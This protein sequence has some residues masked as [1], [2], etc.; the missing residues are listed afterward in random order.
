MTPSTLILKIHSKINIKTDEV[1][2]NIMMDFMPEDLYRLLKFYRKQKQQFPN[3]LVKL[4][5]Y[6]MLRSIAYIHALGICHRD[7]KPQNMLV[8]PS[9][10]NLKLCDFGSAKKLIKGIVKEIYK[11]LIINLFTF[12]N[13]VNPTLPIYVLDTTGRQN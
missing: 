12:T 13:K 11:F 7:I 2:L 10:H 5:S 3:V 9:N 6:Q 4:Y 8:D 1:Y